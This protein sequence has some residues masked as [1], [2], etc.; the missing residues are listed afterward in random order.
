MK[1]HDATELAYKNGYE[2][3]QSE[4]L[5]T[6]EWVQLDNKHWVC[7][8]CDRTIKMKKKNHFPLDEEEQYNFCPTCGR[9]M[10]VHL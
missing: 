1:L 3:G 8:N 2:A 10:T 9:K 4:I 5:H 6:S 7:L